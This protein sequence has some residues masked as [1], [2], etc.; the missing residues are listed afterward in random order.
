MFFL[1]RGLR[2]FRK[3]KMK[4]MFAVF[5][6]ETSRHLEYGMCVC[7][8]LL[9]NARHLTSSHFPRVVFLLG[10]ML[11]KSVVVV[12]CVCLC[13]CCDSGEHVRLCREKERKRG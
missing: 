9:H 3:L 13:V 7:C 5:M 12:S 11:N 4:R 6:N 2:G 1:E 8:H 10:L